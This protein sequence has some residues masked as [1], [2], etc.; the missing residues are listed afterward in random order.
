[1]PH[2]LSNGPNVVTSLKKAAG[3]YAGAND[4]HGTPSPARLYNRGQITIKRELHHKV[5]A[6]RAG[7]GRAGSFSVCH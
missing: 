2:Q 7:A 1:V 3:G 5:C 6:N 4:L